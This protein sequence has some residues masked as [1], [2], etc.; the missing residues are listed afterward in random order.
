MLALAYLGGYLLNDYVRKGLPRI[1]WAIAIPLALMVV[2]VLAWAISFASIL[3]K[4]WDAALAIAKVLPIYAALLVLLIWPKTP[5]LRLAAASIAVAFTAGELVVLN[6]ASSMNAEPRAY[7]AFLEKPSGRDASII[8]T[9]TREMKRR[10]V[11]ALRPRVE[12]VGLGAPGRT[13]PWS[14]A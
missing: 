4:S 10:G 11:G 2:G 8:A 6:A 13:P 1:H 9:L 5:C 3:N 7:Y 14:M 12:I